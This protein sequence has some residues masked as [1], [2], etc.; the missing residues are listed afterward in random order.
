MI[1]FARLGSGEF[2][3]SGCEKKRNDTYMPAVKG[4]TQF[5]HIKQF[6]QETAVLRRH[7]I[8]LRLGSVLKVTAFG[9]SQLIRC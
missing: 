6:G 5:G 4:S 8:R 3:T 2:V 9:L 7:G 1:R